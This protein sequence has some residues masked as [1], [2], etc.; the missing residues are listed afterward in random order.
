MCRA[1][2]SLGVPTDNHV[3]SLSMVG[4]CGVLATTSSSFRDNSAIN[5]LEKCGGGQRELPGGANVNAYCRW[6]NP[7]KLCACPAIRD[8]R[9]IP[10]GE[11]GATTARPWAVR[12]ESISHDRGGQR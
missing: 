8:I 2:L 11:K 6:M 7:A 1:D 4:G 9:L 3:R 5:I 10:P 12:Q